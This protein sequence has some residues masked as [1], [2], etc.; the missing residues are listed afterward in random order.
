M[1]DLR[2]CC[3]CSITISFSPAEVNYCKSCI[4]S[5]NKQPSVEYNNPQKKIKSTESLEEQIERETRLFP[6]EIKKL[7]K[8]EADGLELI[9]SF[10]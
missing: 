8:W 4:S 10:G 2:G 5:K 6:E 3:L 1:A 9:K 7:D